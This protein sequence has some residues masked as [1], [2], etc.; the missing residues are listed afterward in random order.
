MKSNIFYYSKEN[1]FQIIGK[2]DIYLFVFSLNWHV[3]EC[4]NVSDHK[5]QPSKLSSIGG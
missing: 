1:I 5:M 4:G 3:F 2:R